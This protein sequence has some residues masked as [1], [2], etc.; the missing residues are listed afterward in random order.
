MSESTQSLNSISLYAHIPFCLSKCPYCDFNTYQGIESQ[1][2]DF[3]TAVSG[4][5]E[6]WARALGQPSVNTIFLGGGTPSYL[7]DGDVGRILETI[8][9]AYPVRSDAEI[10]AECNP[11]DLTAAK[12]A[13]LRA[14]GINRISMGAQSM[15]DGL[16]AMLG[17]RH[18]AAEAVAALESCRRAGFDN[19]NLDLMY[20]LPQQ[21]LE[22][23]R[24]TVE[25]TLAQ[26]PEHI[27]MYSLTLEEGTPLK[28]WV[29][30]GRLPE[31]D[32]DLAADMYDLA[33]ST[34][35]DAGYE[36]YEISN[37]SQ[38]G[39]ESEHNLAYWRN[40]QWL[41]VGPGAHS[42]LRTV[43]SADGCRFW[44]VRSPR[45]YARKAGQ[46]SANAGRWE[47]VTAAGIESVPTVDGLEVIDEATAAAE[48][49]FLGLRLL[50]GMDVGEAS[51]RVG[52]DLAA[53]YERELA[54]LTAEGLLMW[55]DDGRLRLAEEAYLVANQVFTRFL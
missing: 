27:S 15:D 44:T 28:R 18:D 43:E 47:S 17:R 29:E 31:P 49:M 16:L 26:S 14:A 46:W 22:Q 50:D 37:W 24:D 13:E 1:F 21:T 12:C 25:R 38:A 19:V 5:I 34:L 9:D 54:E 45:D 8:A 39:R 53:N 3:L 33:R 10:T 7:P 40:L 11:N 32:Q 42:S 23:W 48:T 4:E 41:G 51:A 30:Q 6:A 36:H 20:G 52:I 35:K 55:E 2:G